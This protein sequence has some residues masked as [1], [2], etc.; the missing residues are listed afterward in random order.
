[1]KS[2]TQLPAGTLFLADNVALDFINTQ[3]G[4]GDH[5]HDGFTDDNSV[6]TWLQAAKLLSPEVQNKAPTGLLVLARQLRNQARE[7]VAAAMTGSSAKSELI[8]Q[9]LELGRPRRELTWDSENN[10]YKLITQIRDNSPACLLEP[11]AKAL[12]QLL[13][14]SK[15]EYVRCCEADDC[16]LLFHDLTKSHR[17]RWCSMATCGNRMKVAAFRARKG[18]STNG[19]RLSKDGD[20]P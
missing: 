19:K 11:V 10:A 17:R 6:M 16:V 9:I 20:K 1:M 3:Y 7:V 12:A 14:S 8:N 2:T 18:N 13:T 4:A 5:H 15:F